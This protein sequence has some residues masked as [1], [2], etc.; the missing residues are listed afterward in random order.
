MDYQVIYYSKT[1]RQNTKRIAET[2]ARALKVTA[3]RATPGLKISHCKLLFIGS[4][5][6]IWKVGKPLLDLID[7]MP[8]MEGQKAVIFLTHGGNKDQALEE[9]KT[10]LEE[11]G[12]NIIDTWDC[13]GHWAFFSRGHPEEQDVQDAHNFTVEIAKKAESMTG[14]EKGELETKE[15]P[16]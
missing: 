15:T 10:K 8:Q 14:L 9:L 3:K 11:K 4:G 5:V 2:I 13:L 7:K 12:C 16:Q 6:Y 1:S